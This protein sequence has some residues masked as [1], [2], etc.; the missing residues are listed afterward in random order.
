LLGQVHAARGEWRAAA[1]LY[2][3]GATRAPEFGL[4]RLLLERIAATLRGAGDA[5]AADD[6]GALPEPAAGANR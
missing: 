1:S 4:N 2:R 6:L 5:R 3:D